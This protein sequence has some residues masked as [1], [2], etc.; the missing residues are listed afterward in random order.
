MF[1]MLGE[2]DAMQIGKNNISAV[3]QL[4]EKECIPLMA[5]DT[6]KSIGRTMRFSVSENTIT[7]STKEGHKV[8]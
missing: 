6:G 1:P 7:I 8:I 3:K 4:L 5:E 2:S